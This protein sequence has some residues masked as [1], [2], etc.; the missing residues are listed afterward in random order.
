VAPEPHPSGDERFRLLDAAMKRHGRQP[1]ALIEVLHAAQDLFGRLDNDLLLYVA[2][3]LMLP[4]SRVYGTATF[5]HLFTFTPKGEHDCVV[6][7]G[8]ACYVKGGADLLAALERRLGVSAG[9][10]RAD[11]RVSLRTARCVGASGLAPVVV[12]DGDT[13]GGLTPEAALGRVK[14]WCDDGPR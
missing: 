10:T 3:G 13:V 1:D 8:T 11:G 14:G 6:C 7:L 12:F 9:Q 4:P 2:R 5:Y